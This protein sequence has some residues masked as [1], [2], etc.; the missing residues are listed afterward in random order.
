M[1]V[2]GD[3]TMKIASGSGDE[4]R[5]LPPSTQRLLRLMQ[6]VNHGRIERLF[7]RNGEPVWDPAPK[8]FYS[9]K[10]GGEIGGRPEREAAGFALKTAVKDLRRDLARHGSGLVRFIVVKNGLPLVWEIEKTS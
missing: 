9:G 5:I 4:F 10:A 2:A 6:E 8:P 7:F 3:K 1:R